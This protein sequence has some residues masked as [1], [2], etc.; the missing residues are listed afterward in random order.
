M[1]TRNAKLQLR[2]SNSSHMTIGSNLLF[3]YDKSEMENIQT[4]FIEQILKQH[5]PSSL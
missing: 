3:I 4:A 2:E 1:R 5:L